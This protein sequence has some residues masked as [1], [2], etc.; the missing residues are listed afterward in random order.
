LPPTAT[1]VGPLTPAGRKFVPEMTI[2]SPG[3]AGGRA[4]SPR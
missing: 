2:A 3:R 4:A 1:M